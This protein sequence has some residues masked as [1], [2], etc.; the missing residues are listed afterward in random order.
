MLPA[1]AHTKATRRL[2]HSAT[3]FLQKPNCG[4]H[5]SLLLATLEDA[6]SCR[7]C[8]MMNTPCHFRLPA[9][10]QANHS[11]WRAR[12]CATCLFHSLDEVVKQPFTN[13]YQP[14]LAARD[15]LRKKKHDDAH[16][17]VVI[18]TTTKS[19]IQTYSAICHS[20]LIDG[21][22]VRQSMRQWCGH[23]Q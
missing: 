2:G 20:K 18:M 1:G 14:S 11:F 6:G 9:L 15:N 8:R 3:T 17:N 13:K 19:Y 22:P 5:I 7:C 12:A 4:C 21:G 10:Q 16:T 23:S